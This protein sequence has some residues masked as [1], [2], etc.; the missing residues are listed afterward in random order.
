MGSGKWGMLHEMQL[1][2]YLIL[3]I[4][5]VKVG[6]GGG[7]YVGVC[8]ING[9]ALVP[10]QQP[11]KCYI[12]LQETRGKSGSNLPGLNPGLLNTKEH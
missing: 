4:A 8:D 12:A 6:L 11:G 7:A 5:L 1:Y 9:C 3:F 10:P 2:N